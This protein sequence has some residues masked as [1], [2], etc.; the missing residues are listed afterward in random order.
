MYCENIDQ[1]E[2]GVTISA[3]SKVDFK[4]SIVT[5]NKEEHFTMIKESIHNSPK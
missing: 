2:V 1:K 5:K 4:G 3:L